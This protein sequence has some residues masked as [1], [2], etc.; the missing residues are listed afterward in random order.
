MGT[1]Q[2]G[3]ANKLASVRLYAGSKRSSILHPVSPP[4]VV[5]GILVITHIAYIIIVPYH[6][7]NWGGGANVFLQAGDIVEPAYL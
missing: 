5:A 3:Y 7:Q 4:L 2:L 6:R 1:E